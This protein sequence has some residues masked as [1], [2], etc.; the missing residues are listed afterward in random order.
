MNNEFV[1][2]DIL[3]Y[4]YNDR[5]QIVLLDVLANTTF[6]IITHTEGEYEYGYEVPLKALSSKYFKKIG[7]LE[8]RFPS[9]W[10]PFKHEYCFL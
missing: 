5:V 6:T 2:G 1:V 4:S 7:H 10:E 8:E 3:L 9:K